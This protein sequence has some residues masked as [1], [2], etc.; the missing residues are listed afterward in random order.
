MEEVFAHALEVEETVGA[1]SVSRRLEGRKYLVELIITITAISTCVE[2]A[3]LLIGDSS[4][5]V[6]FRGDYCTFQGENDS[7]SAF[8]KELYLTT[9]KL[10]A[11]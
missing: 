3:I 10:R 5:K 8:L 6:C 1:A 11:H 9:P 2:L 7:S 4:A